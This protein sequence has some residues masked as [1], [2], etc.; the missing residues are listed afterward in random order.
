MGTAQ[1]LQQV[2]RPG[3]LSLALMPEHRLNQLLKCHHLYL[4]DTKTQALVMSWLSREL[5]ETQDRDFILYPKPQDQ[6]SFKT[7]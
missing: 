4:P 3:S 7:G 6:L 2:P 1:P 5:S